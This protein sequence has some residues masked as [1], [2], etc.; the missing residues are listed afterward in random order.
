MSKFVNGLSGYF[1]SFID[2]LG[3]TATVQPYAGVTPASISIYDLLRHLASNLD[4]YHDLLGYLSR[5]DFK[6]VSIQGLRNPT[7]AVCEVYESTLWPGMIRENDDDS[8]LPLV[9]GPQVTNPDNL[10]AAILRVWEASNWNENKDTA[11]YDAA[12]LGDQLFK[13]VGDAAGGQVYFQI[14]QPDYLTAFTPDPRGYLRWIRT[15]VPETRTLANGTTETIW[16]TEVWDKETGTLR[17]WE[18]KDGPTQPVERLGTPRETVTFAAIFGED[19]VPFVH[20][21]FKARSGQERGVAAVM[22][23]LDK[24]IAGDALVTALFQRL[25]N[26][27]MPDEIIT[28]S[29]IDQNGM[30][31]P[32]L[33]S[34]SVTQVDVA[35]VMRYSLPGGYQ[36]TSTV[37]QLQY[38]E[39][40][41][42]I[43]A[44]YQALKRDDL[45]ELSFNEVSEAGGDLSGKALNYKLGPTKAKVDRAR[46]RGESALVRIT[47]MCL[48]AG[49]NLGIAGFS[50]AEIGTFEAGNFDFWFRD[51]PLIPTSPE[52][53]ADLDTS[54]TQRVKTLVDSGASLGGAMR[55]AGYDDEAVTAATDFSATVEP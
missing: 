27:N 15:D 7:N 36:F 17:V 42:A 37:P 12:N 30:P 24:L 44:H 19:F 13:V 47:Q 2:S 1:R 51:R 29:I 49:Q 21:R 5:T 25:T 10:K 53:Q 31:A 45:I 8:A 34:A 33:R 4:P 9:F 3:T 41:A 20:W 26:H 18:H 32:P 43:E 14:I 16:E 55:V 54:R 35:G 22:H 40:L 28:S 52:D 39:H 6:S 11:A 38:A 48:T 46:G 50:A 23:A